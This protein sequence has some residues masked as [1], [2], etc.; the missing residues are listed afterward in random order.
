MRGKLGLLCGV[1][2]CLPITYAATSSQ[3]DVIQVVDNS[4]KK[5]STLNG[6]GVPA[7]MLKTSAPKNYVVKKTDTVMKLAHMYLKKIGYWPQFLGISSINKTRIYPGDSLQIL[8][9]DG[10]KLLTVSHAQ[11]TTIEKLEPEVHDL[12]N[13]ELPTISIKK[14]KNLILRPTLIP[15]GEFEALPMV[16]S[17]GAPGDF[18]YTAGDNIY[19]KGLKEQQVGDQ[20]SVFSK[21]RKVSDPDTKESLGFEV[22]YN[23]DATITQIGP[24]SSLELTS[25][26]NYVSPL[27]RVIS[28]PVQQIPDLTPHRSESMVITGKIVALYDAIT[29][30]A[31]DNTVI[32][33]RGSRDGVDPGMIFDITDTRKVIDPTSNMD[34]PKYLVMPPTVIGELLIYK[35]YDK[36]SFGLIT[37]S[38]RPILI[39]SIIQSQ[40]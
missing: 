29:S 14:L 38:A 1:F 36:M 5:S 23:G 13:D 9:I 30:T 31:E 39:N 16:V 33:N 32:I 20:V 34:H 37:D 28:L 26:V 3:G 7:N 2:A 17:G 25:T 27:D 8:T 24:I 22:R 12:P 19:V 21:F 18:T 11:G 4:Q 10:V 40:Q 15:E 35:V 6:S